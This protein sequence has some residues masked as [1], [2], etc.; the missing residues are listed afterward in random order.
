MRCSEAELKPSSESGHSTGTFRMLASALRCSLGREGW[1]PFAN[2]NRS[3][4]KGVLSNGSE[5]I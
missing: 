1:Q 2:R 5:P 3:L 4:P